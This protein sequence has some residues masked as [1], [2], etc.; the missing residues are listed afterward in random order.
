[1]AESRGGGEVLG[2]GV[3][4]LRQGAVAHHLQQAEF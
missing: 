3:V 4:V 2:Q 1:M